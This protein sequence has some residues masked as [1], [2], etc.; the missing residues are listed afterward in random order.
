ME[1]SNNDLFSGSEINDEDGMKEN[2]RS[3]WKVFQYRLISLFV[4]SVGDAQSH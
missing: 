3:S 2:I 1:A 4:N